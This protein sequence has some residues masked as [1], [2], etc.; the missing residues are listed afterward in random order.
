[1]SLKQ[2]QEWLDQQPGIDKPLYA[3]MVQLDGDGEY[4][5][6]WLGMGYPETT[7]WIQN[8]AWCDYDIARDIAQISFGKIFHIN[9]EIYEVTRA[10]I[11]EKDVEY[12]VVEEVEADEH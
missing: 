10:F 7:V 3:V 11:V 5:L 1:M 9:G 2:A 4:Q 12:R 6:I 8:A